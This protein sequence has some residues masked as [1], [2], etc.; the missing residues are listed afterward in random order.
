MIQGETRSMKVNRSLKLL[1]LALILPGS[2]LFSCQ[3]VPENKQPSLMEEQLSELIAVQQ[4]EKNKSGQ[5]MDELPPAEVLDALNPSMSSL[6]KDNEAETRFDLAV[7]NAP[8]K[9]FFMGLVEGTQWNVIV[10]PE[11][12]G[13]ITLDL[14]N[15][16][17]SL[18]MDIVRNIYGFEYSKIDNVYEIYPATV[19]TVMFQ[20]N[21]LNI[22]RRGN[23]VIRVNSGEVAENYSSGPTN[24]RGSNSSNQTTQGGG[25]NSDNKH[26]TQIETTSE[27][28]FWAELTDTLKLLI[29]DNP[30][31]RVMASPQTSMVI[32]RAL[33]AEIRIIS[34]Y[35][36]KVQN[37]M[38]RQV[39]LEARIL[40]VILGDSYQAGIDWSSLATVNGSNDLNFTQNGRNVTNSDPSNLLAGI[41]SASYQSSNFDLMIDLL[42]TQGYVQVLSSPRISTLNN[43]K[44][45]IKVGTDEFFVTDISS[46]T[47]AGGGTS[48]TSPDVT[49]TP[50][51]SGIALDVTPQ[52][53]E[54]GNII[55][56]VHPTISE[57]VDQE[58]LLTLGDDQI[59]LPL[60]KSTIRESDSI[61][62][63]KSGQVV[64]I[65]GLMQTVTDDSDS[66]IPLLK[67]VSGLGHLFKQTN[68]KNRKTELIILIRPQLV[69]DNTW[70]DYLKN[71]RQRVGRMGKSGG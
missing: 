20:V 17:L 1:R 51:F 64:V 68:M 22:K 63:A 54:L 52:I 30:K 34:S 5:G 35:L 65:G 12:S 44:A 29:A 59:T 2:L 32:V 23:S 36:K 13:N 33:P 40:E 14:K 8:A 37:V 31:A 70:G 66:G 42:S 38:H 41:F 4:A 3:T 19:E 53:D 71:S 45:V 61:I 56:H 27:S 48:T 11:V 18:V 24:N 28:D 21:Y 26:S 60:A 58:K 9:E 6:L 25:N 46:T 67:D 39:L 16:S 43:Q 50:F 49:L 47:T 57:V 69:D 15:V 7:N 62:R 10:S 55:L